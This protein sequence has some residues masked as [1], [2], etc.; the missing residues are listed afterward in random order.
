MTTLPD[1]IARLTPQPR[2][3]GSDP[4]L[5]WAERDPAAVKRSIVITLLL[6]AP[7]AFFAPAAF[8]AAAIGAAAAAYVNARYFQ[9]HLTA[10]ELRLRAAALSPVVCVPLT[11]ISAAKVVEDPGGFLMPMA[12]RSGHLLIQKSDGAQ[13][14]IPGI[15]DVAEAVEA[16][17]RLKNPPAHTEA[18]AA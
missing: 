12:P 18:Q 5:F 4:M 11:E 8:L 3:D 1:N 17:Q 7:L 16:I 10:R 2:P 9:L 15:K 13:L 14:L 6:M